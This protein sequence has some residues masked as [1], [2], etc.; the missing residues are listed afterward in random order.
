MDIIVGY[1]NINIIC[2]Q[3][4]LYYNISVLYCGYILLFQRPNVRGP[5]ARSENC[6]QC[7]GKTEANEEVAKKTT[8][9]KRVEPFHHLKNIP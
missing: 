5:V 4:I 9:V 8:G 7:P 3:D 6:S 2:V 1:N